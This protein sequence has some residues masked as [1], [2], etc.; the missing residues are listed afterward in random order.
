MLDED[1]VLK[2]AIFRNRVYDKS[3]AYEA[4]IALT[5]E[6]CIFTYTPVK[7]TYR[8][9]MSCGHAIDPNNLYSFMF[10]EVVNGEWEIKCP[11]VS[12]KNP[13]ERCG[14]KWGY[15]ELRKMALL[16]NHEKDFLRFIC[17][18]IKSMD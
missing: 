9:V 11:F 8:G 12:Q 1:G 15:E 7:A 4:G 16:D 18:G 5:H 14:E 2:A 3:H 10:Y 17:L 13:N 6:P